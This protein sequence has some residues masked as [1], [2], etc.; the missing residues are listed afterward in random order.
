MGVRAFG[1]VPGMKRRRLARLQNR[2]KAQK[3][4]Y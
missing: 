3:K 4:L 1:F 2:G